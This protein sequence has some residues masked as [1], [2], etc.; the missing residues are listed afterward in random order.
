[1]A[2]PSPSILQ[3]NKPRLLAP[4]WHTVVLILFILATAYFQSRNHIEN[5]KIIHRVVLYSFMICF[6]WFLFAYVWFLGIRP[7]GRKLSEIIG[8]RWATARDVW[9][10]IGAA[11][12]FWLIVIAFLAAAGL[13][14]GPN[15]AMQK[16]VQ[17]IMPR[18]PLEMFAWVLLSISAGICEEFV[19]RGYLQKQFLA[20]TGSNAA[21]IATQ[22]LIFGVAHLYQGVKG[23]VIITL[24]GALFGILAVARQS[25][26]PGMIQHALQDTSSG[27]GFSLLAK[28]LPKPPSF[29]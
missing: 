29:F 27:I 25:L 24:Y 14:L 20:L 3:S 8:G 13:V 28:H 5:H 22:A 17:V 19:F 10:D 2:V 1:M 15:S 26:R 23:L 7:T 21:A 11:L 12:V 9:R 6:E 4:L 18:S 16:V